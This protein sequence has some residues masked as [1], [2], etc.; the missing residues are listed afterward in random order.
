MP[1][2]ARGAPAHFQRVVPTPCVAGGEAHA[3]AGAAEH[4]VGGGSSCA[5]GSSSRGS[6]PAEGAE[7]Q[8]TEFEAGLVRLQVSRP[9]HLARLDLMSRRS[10]CQRGYVETLMFFWNVEQGWMAC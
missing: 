3:T 8:V 9:G 1:S 2:G 6:S 5:A 7:Q 10:A 4:G